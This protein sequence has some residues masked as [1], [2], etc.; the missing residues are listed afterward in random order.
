MAATK[1]AATTSIKSL[2]L[3]VKGMKVGFKDLIFTSGQK[4]TLSTWIEE[5][6]QVKVTIEPTEKLLTDDQDGDEG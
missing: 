5:R 3:E 4:D 1:I 6:R 2:T